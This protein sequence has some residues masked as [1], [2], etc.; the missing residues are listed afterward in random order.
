MPRVHNKHEKFGAEPN[1]I[2]RVPR[3]SGELH[4]NGIKPPNRQIKK[5][6]GGVTEVTEQIT[7]CALSR[8]IGKMSAANQVIPPSPLFY[9]HL[10]M[11]LTESLRVSDH[12]YDTTLTLSH[13]NKEELTWWDTQRRKW[14]GQHI[15]AKEPDLVIEL[16]AST[17]GWGAS[18]QNINTGGPWSAQEKTNHINCLELLAATLALKT[19]VKNQTGGVSLA[20]DRQ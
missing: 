7:N 14:N 11:D 9:R 10:Q 16:D 13:E 19:F 20:Q 12:N 17:L 8:L 2:S 4:N 18:C 6:Q 1:P 15:L 5:D 3:L